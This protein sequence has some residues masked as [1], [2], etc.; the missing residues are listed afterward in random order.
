MSKRSVI[1]C[2]VLF[3]LGA[4]LLVSSGCTPQAGEKIPVTTSSAEALE[5]YLQGRDLAEKLLVADAA[6]YFEQAIEADSD[7]AMAYL[8][9]SL[10][11]HT[12]VGFFEYLGRAMDL[13]GQ[14]SEGERLQIF[15]VQA[16]ADQDPWKQRELYMK[17]VEAYPHDERAHN[18]LA[19]NY[20]G[21]QEYPPA[22]AEFEEAARINPEFSQPYNQL[23]YAYRF[24]GKYGAAEKAFQK[25]IELIPDDPNP[26]DSYADLLTRMGK[27]DAAIE[28]FEKSL[29][30]DSNFI[31]SRLGI[32][33]NLV[34]KGDYE[35]ARARIDQAYNMA[36]HDGERRAA[37]FARAIT[38]VDEGDYDKAIGELNM[39]HALAMA[40]NDI[41][42]MANDLGTMGRVYFE[43][44]K[45]D[46][47]MAMYEQ[48]VEVIAASDL[49]DEIKENV[50][51][52]YVFRSATVAIKKGQVAKA[53][54]KAMTYFKAAT[55][56]QS[57]NQIRA[58][59]QLLGM[60]ALEEGDYERAVEELLQA[61]RLSPYNLY[62]LALAYKGAGD[63]K[64]ARQYAKEAVNFNALTSLSY[65]FCRHKA[66]E[67]L[68]SL[69]ESSPDEDATI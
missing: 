52:G 4:L 51:L 25:Y 58:A 62:R 34:F 23:G 6:Q 33:S 65:A 2:T 42:T 24:M 29:A 44:G 20:F 43:Q 40:N 10:S 32:A 12:T 61:S 38:Y 66:Q 68:E 64:N 9:L 3:A 60:I 36:R 30:Q 45:Y 11:Q 17:L 54:K 57:P 31:A 49:S 35:A 28:Q 47:A 46:E 19:N 22:I 48:A 18:L 26:Y 1:H 63:I 56:R 37:I 55:N 50:E 39:Q 69:P 13:S 41:A 53:R 16:A 67:L 7:F 14:V 21:Q 8:Y 5:Y 15:A 59:H 27:Y